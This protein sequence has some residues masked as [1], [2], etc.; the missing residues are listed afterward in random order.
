[1][2]NK[3]Y[4]LEEKFHYFLKTKYVYKK[5]HQE[6]CALLVAPSVT[7]RVCRFYMKFLRVFPWRLLYMQV[8]LASALENKKTTLGYTKKVQ[9]VQH[10]C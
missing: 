6:D 7:L 8:K 2:K 3:C 9:Q 4:I 5:K 1:M 10:F